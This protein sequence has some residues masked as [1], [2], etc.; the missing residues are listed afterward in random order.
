MVLSADLLPAVQQQP[1]LLNHSRG[2]VT[3]SGRDVRGATASDL[4]AGLA[5]VAQSGCGA[6]SGTA[7][8]RMQ[9]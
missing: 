5:L 9:H 4:A 8:R 3:H 7:V 1:D 6:E 2:S